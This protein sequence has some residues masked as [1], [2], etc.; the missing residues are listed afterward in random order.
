M[1]LHLSFEESDFKDLRS[2][3]RAVKRQV[4]KNCYVGTDSLCLY[5]A[6][7]KELAAMLRPYP[8]TKQL[9]FDLESS[10]PEA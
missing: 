7:P 1:K 6:F 3:D 10:L 5:F 2:F 9:E 8:P 4:G